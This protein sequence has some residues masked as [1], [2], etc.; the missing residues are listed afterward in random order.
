MLRN[1]PKWIESLTT[2]YLISTVVAS[3]CL[4][5]LL[6][7]GIL[8]T[9]VVSLAD[10]AKFVDA[11]LKLSVVIIG[12]LWTVNRYFVQGTDVLQ[13]RVDV[14]LN[15]IRVNGNDKAIMIYRLDIFNTGNSQLPEFKHF[16]AIERIYMKNN[17]LKVEPLHRWPEKGSHGGGPIEPG[18]WSA[19]N[20]QILCP[21]NTVAVRVFVEIQT[22]SQGLWTWH[23]T[24]DV[25]GGKVCEG[26]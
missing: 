19:I 7:F 12:G 26:L 21:K 5:A 1:S 4:P 18:S 16:V 9:G 10:T 23:K 13:L 6:L 22:L 2:K 20:E 3:L 14:D 8:Q 25:T 17:E 11:S 15:V 24:F